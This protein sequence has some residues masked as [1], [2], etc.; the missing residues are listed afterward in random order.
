MNYHK[1]TTYFAKLYVTQLKQ[2]MP[3]NE[4]VQK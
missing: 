4:K 2:E 3:G 1:N